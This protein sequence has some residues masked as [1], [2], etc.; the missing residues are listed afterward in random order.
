MK[1]NR[2]TEISNERLKKAPEWA[3]FKHYHKLTISYYRDEL[4]IR[5]KLWFIIGHGPERVDSIYYEISNTA[6]FKTQDIEKIT[7]ELEIKMIKGIINH[8]NLII[9]YRLKEIEKLTTDI[10]Q[11]NKNNK[12][13]SV[14][15]REDKIKRILK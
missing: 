15:L 10:K 3:N 1:I 8:N 2:T 12:N 5:K 7:P 14:Y 11:I 6:V 13:I 9:A 4:T